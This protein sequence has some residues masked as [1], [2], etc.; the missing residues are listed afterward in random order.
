MIINELKEPNRFDM[1]KL[2]YLNLSDQDVFFKSLG[3]CTSELLFLLNLED[4]R[5]KAEINQFSCY[6]EQ[7]GVKCE[8]VYNTVTLIC[9]SL[10]K[11]NVILT[12]SLRKLGYEIVLNI[13]YILKICRTIVFDSKDIDRINEIISEYMAII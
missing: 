8:L 2:I 9:S 11:S 7:V 6:E 3:Y 4:S 1:F 10:V 13:L 12:C 5:I